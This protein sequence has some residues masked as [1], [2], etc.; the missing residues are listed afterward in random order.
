MKMARTRV[1][2]QREIDE[3]LSFG[4]SERRRKRMWRKRREECQYDRYVDDWERESD[5]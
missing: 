2:S 3:L 1:L 5:E 4:D